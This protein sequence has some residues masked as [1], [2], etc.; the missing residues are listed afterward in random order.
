MNLA[1]SLGFVSR[2]GSLKNLELLEFKHHCIECRV[3][4]RCVT[5]EPEAHQGLETRTRGRNG[6]P[7]EVSESCSLPNNAKSLSAWSWNDTAKVSTQYT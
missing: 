7:C 6:L 1:S 2:I 3:L 5:D 4:P